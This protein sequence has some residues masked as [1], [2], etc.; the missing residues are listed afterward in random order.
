M[1]GLLKSYEKDQVDLIVKELI[2][3]GY[4]KEK[5]KKTGKYSVVFL[6][7]KRPKLNEILN[8]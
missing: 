5:L 1:Y 7:I 3:Q 6:E 2:S 4:L 8:N